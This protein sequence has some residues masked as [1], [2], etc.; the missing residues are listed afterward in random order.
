[1]PFNES[2]V[3]QCWGYSNPFYTELLPP[4]LLPLP[5][6]FPSPSLFLAEVLALVLAGRYFGAPLGAFLQVVF[7]AVVMEHA[8]RVHSTVNPRA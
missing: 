5:S 6:P 4:P 2:E 1:M 8:L 7:P 3:K